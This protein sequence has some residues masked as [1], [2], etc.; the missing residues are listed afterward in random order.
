MGNLVPL[1]LARVINVNGPIQ[2]GFV[3]AYQCASN[4]DANALCGWLRV[5]HAAAAGGGGGGGGAALGQCRF[6]ST[7]GTMRVF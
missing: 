6:T 4:D 1:E 7:P 5:R 2:P 3:A